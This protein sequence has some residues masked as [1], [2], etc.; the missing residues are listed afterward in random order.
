AGLTLHVGIHAGDVI[1]EEG[2]VYGGAVN[3]AARVAGQ[4]AAGETLVSGTVRDLARTSAGV[5]FE[6]RGER[7]L[8]GVGEPVRVYAVREQGGA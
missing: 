3:I 1:R 5:S 4:A 7:E 8:K 2:N 6:D